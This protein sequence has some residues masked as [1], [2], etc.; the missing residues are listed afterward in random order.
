MVLNGGVAGGH[1][2]VGRVL[3]LGPGAGHAR[4]FTAD[5]SSCVRGTFQCLVESDTWRERRPRPDWARSLQ[6]PHH[7]SSFFSSAP[8]VT[9]N[10]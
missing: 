1:G 5:S 10:P 3:F 2:E 4:V 9:W 7:F 6:P 8:E